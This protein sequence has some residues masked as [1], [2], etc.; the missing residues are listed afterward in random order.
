MKTYL[1]RQVIPEALNK[2]DG[3]QTKAAELLKINR[4]TLRTKMTKIGI[5]KKYFRDK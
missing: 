2:T 1:D 3:N 5:K 4:T